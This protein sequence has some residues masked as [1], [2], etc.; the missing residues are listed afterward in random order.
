M[1]FR[2]GWKLSLFF[3]ILLPCLI[4]L[5]FW[6][7]ERAQEKRQILQRLSDRRSEAP[8]G[9][10]DVQGRSEPAYSQVS[11]AGRFDNEHLVLLDN[12]LYQKQ[13]GYEV[14]QPFRLEDD[15]LVMISRGWVAG[16]LLRDELPRVVP[17][18]GPKHIVGEVYVPLGK[19]FALAEEP[20]PVGWPK[21]VQ[22]LDVAMIEKELKEPVYPYVLRL[23]AGSAGLLAPYWQDI[24]VQPEKHTGYAVQWFAMA[25][26][27]IL[28]Y[29]GAGLGLIKSK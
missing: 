1:V 28:L 16:S 9:L 2:P 22:T 11:L 7:L 14:V 27:L 10:F 5:G 12:R 19:A 21:R 24:N 17:V 26:A 18:M 29:L 8:V 3:L 4:S 20:L 13:F 6:Q 23:R 25:A 15:S